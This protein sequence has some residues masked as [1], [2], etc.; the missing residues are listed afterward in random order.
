MKRTICIISVISILVMQ[1]CRK[2][3]TEEES[4]CLSAS[5]IAW[6]SSGYICD[7]GASVKAYYFQGNTVYTFEPGNCGADMQAL[8]IDSHCNQIGALGGIAGNHMING[9]DFS[10]A[11]YIKTVWKK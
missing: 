11:V 7:N 10:K 6:S 1:S 8:V 2:E 5:I 3:K 9:A 4:E